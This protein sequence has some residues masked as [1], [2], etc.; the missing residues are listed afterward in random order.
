MLLGLA[1]CGAPTGEL[2]PASPGAG[3]A[4][5]TDLLR[6]RLWDDGFAEV[7][8]YAG[9]E[10]RYGELRA[11][12]L[13]LI[14]VKEPFDP[15]LL[16]KADG[17]RHARTLDAIKLN[18]ILTVPTGV[19]TYHQMSS[20]FFD[21]AAGRLMKLATTSQ[22]WCGITSKILT[23]RGGRAVLRAFSYF[24]D[25]AD[26]IHPFEMDDDT[27]VADALPLYL[28]TLDLE[29]PGSRELRLLPRQ[30][31][32][33]TTIPV[34]ERAT[35]TV[36]TAETLDVPAGAF[37]AIPVEVRGS[38]TDVYWFASSSPHALVRWDRADGG[39]Y[40]LASVLR[41]DYWDQHAVGDA[42]PPL[43]DQAI[44]P[45]QLEPAPAVQP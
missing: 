19:Y 18:T 26:S 42:L 38:E 12:E 24:G 23:V 33:R 7:A 39:R 1:S 6:S 45:P 25:E 13:V 40:E 8:R 37:E 32:N 16:V 20:A 22:E 4:A 15:D 30:L 28:R 9:T 36:G 43:P 44:E 35:A 11:A 5:E 3:R 31:S 27:V 2:R 21:R 10:R 29:R 14:T 34:P 17:A 41:T